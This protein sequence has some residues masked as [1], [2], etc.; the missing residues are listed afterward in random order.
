VGGEHPTWEAFW[1]AFELFRDPLLCALA[2]GTVLGFLS[3]YVVLRRMVF[4]SAAIT[5]AAAMGVAA[6]FFGG[7]QIGVHIDPIYGAAVM[8]LLATLLFIADPAR[9]RFTR[10]SLLGMVFS[11]CGGVAV[12]LASRVTQEQNEI[13]NIIFGS[14]VVVRPFDLHIVSGVGATILALHLWWFRGLTFASF[15]PAVARVQGLPTRLLGAVVFLSIGIMVGVS[16]RALGALPVFAFS[17]LPAT[18]ALLLARR[19]L[20]LTFI[21]AGLLGGVAGLGGYV[22]AFFLEF[23][24]GAS[25][26]VVAAGIVVVA[27]LVRLVR[28]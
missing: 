24:V 27:L 20:W 12:L 23:P 5:Q 9:L 18:A 7:M 10:D 3:V 6:A 17:T 22:F 19:R 25:Q 13:Q 2:A 4:V 1:G 15:D 8:S 16:A 26:T 28:R 14:A 11:V 21:F